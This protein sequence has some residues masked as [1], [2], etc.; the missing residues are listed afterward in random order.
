[1]VHDSSP[2]IDHAPVKGIYLNCGWGTGGFKAIPG[3]GVAFAH[4][5]A[6]DR[7]HPAAA[8]FTLRRFASGALIDEGAA[9]GIS[10]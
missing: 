8:A 5:L 1:V 4:L 6:T 2:I 3:G 9:A 7:P 10:H